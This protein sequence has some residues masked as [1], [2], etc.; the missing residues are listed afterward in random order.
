[1][2]TQIREQQTQQGWEQEPGVLPQ[3]EVRCGGRIAGLSRRQS[4]GD[5]IPGRRNSMNKES[6]AESTQ[7]F[8]EIMSRQMWLEAQGVASNESES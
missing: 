2:Q 8:Q 6:R 1:M 7:C 5:G 3:K 4:V